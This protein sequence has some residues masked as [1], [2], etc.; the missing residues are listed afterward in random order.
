MG[1]KEVGMGIWIRE[2]LI[3]REKPPG[4]R[5][6]RLRLKILAPR[7]AVLGRHMPEAY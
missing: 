5:S 4:V 1:A 3:F 6:A 7:V 2:Q